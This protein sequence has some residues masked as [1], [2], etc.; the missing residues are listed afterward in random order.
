MFVPNPT[1]RFL[2]D[3]LDFTEAKKEI[4]HSKSV[5]GREHEMAGGK[6]TKMKNGGNKSGQSQDDKDCTIF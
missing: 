5:K 6:P 4:K 3:T 2:H 1:E